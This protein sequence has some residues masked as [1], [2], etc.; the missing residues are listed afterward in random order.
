M[1]T[2]PN[3]LAKRASLTPDRKALITKEETWTFRKLHEL[4]KIAANK[5]AAIGI[6]D[7]DHVAVLMGNRPEFLFLLHGLEY[8]GAV[9]VLLNTKLAVYELCYQLVDSESKLLIYD[10]IFE[11][12]AADIFTSIEVK[13]VRLTD[14]LSIEEGNADI[15]S[16]WQLDRVH[17]IIYTSGTTGQPKGVML[18]YGNH[19]WSAVGSTLNLGLYSDDC[20]LCATPIFHVS[21]LSILLRSVFYGIPVYLVNKFEPC[22]VNDAIEK[23]GVTI[24][25]VVSQMLMRM[26]A[27]LGERKY[28]KSF[29][30]ALLGG[31]PAPKP[32]LEMCREKEIP[33][34]QTYGMTET[35]SQI[36]TL[37]SEYMLT[38]LGSAGM[39]LFPAQLRIEKDGAV[40]P[41]NEAGEIVVKGPNVTIG[42]WKKEDAT[43]KNIIDG[44]LYTGDIGYVDEDGFLYVLDRRTD[45]IISGGENIYPAEVE[46][47]ILSHPSVEE[48]GVVGK[49]SVEWGQVP[50]AF[51]KLFD[52]QTATKEDI[53]AHCKERLAKYKV[54]TDVFFVD[55]LPRNASN[56]LMRKELRKWIR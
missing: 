7:G 17:T 54:P 23:Q 36:V 45:L 14:F 15:R 43:K 52:S 37:S 11:E 9:A 31:G 30:C 49:D 39:P 47:V 26:V 51:V 32:L 3:W 8:I 35:A 2:M 12:K 21:G 22:E 44:W 24:I 42:Y 29:R 4:S 10:D 48:A 18:T 53:I 6:K 38:K 25:S 1:V 5:L 33:V 28:P 50:V 41:P 19:W 16:E 46:S 20:W 55:H 27:D 56:K 40:L 34:Y 13:K